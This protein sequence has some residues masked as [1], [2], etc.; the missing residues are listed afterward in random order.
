VGGDVPVRVRELKKLGHD[1]VVDVRGRRSP[2]PVLATKKSI[3]TVPIGGVLEVLATDRTALADLPSWSEKVG[4]EYLGSFTE[5][6]ELHFF[7]RRVS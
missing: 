3:G 6:G 2:G 1:Q 7:L 5:G 4:Q